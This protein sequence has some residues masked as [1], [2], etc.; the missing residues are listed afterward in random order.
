MIRER[1]LAGI[2]YGDAFTFMEEGRQHLNRQLW[3]QAAAS[4]AKVLNS[5]RKASD[6]LRRK[7]A[8]PALKW[9]SSRKCSP[10]WL[11]SGRVI[12]DCGTPAAAAMPRVAIGQRQFPTSK[13]PWISIRAI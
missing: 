12:D 8:F 6:R 10:V 2:T 7:C 13:K 4:F 5:C 1:A 11:S 3:D 9:S